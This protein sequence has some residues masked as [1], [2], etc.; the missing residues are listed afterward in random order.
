MY[1]HTMKSEPTPTVIDLNLYDRHSDKIGTVGWSKASEPPPELLVIAPSPEYPGLTKPGPG[2]LRYFM[3]FGSHS[4][5]E[6]EAIT[7]RR[8]NT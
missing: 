1:D 8:I 3:R 7:Y 2:K 4:Y 6:T 5:H